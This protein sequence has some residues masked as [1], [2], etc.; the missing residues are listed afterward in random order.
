MDFNTSNLQNLYVCRDKL[1]NHV[2]CCF[3]SSSDG[4][5]V[6]ENV[7]GL[8]KVLPLGDLELCHVGKINDVTMEV[9][10]VPSRVVDWNCYQFPESPIKKESKEKE[11]K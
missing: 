4:M 7:V 6:R 11:D 3:M 9:E 5:A 2:I 8:S 1:A 10:K